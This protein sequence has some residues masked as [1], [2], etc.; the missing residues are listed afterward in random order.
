MIAYKKG[1]SPDT[2]R[3]GEVGRHWQEFRGGFSRSEKESSIMAGKVIIGIE[4][5]LSPPFSPCKYFTGAFI[6]KK[7]NGEKD[8]D[9]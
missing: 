7:R 2:S 9:D 4:N 8:G 6:D 1:N 5:L 3:A